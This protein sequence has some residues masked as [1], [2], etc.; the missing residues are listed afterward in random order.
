MK[1]IKNKRRKFPF[2]DRRGEML[3]MNSTLSYNE[4]LKKCN[5]LTK[6][7][8]SHLSFNRMNKN[9]KIFKRHHQLISLFLCYHHQCRHHHSFISFL[10]R[11]VL[12]ILYLITFFPFR[13]KNF[14]VDFTVVSFYSRIYF[15]N[16]VKFKVFFNSNF[17][18]L[19]FL[20]VEL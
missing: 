19:N 17:E 5:S 11:V 3:S 15:K 8:A 16:L 7:L 2:S 1:R 4:R 10:S 6:F 14:D 12:V 9:E 18:A 20:K 13:S